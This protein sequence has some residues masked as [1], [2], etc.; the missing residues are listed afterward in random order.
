MNIAEILKQP[1]GRRLEFK[2]TLPTVADLAK[3]IVAFSNDAGGELFIG[4]QDNP[5]E[6]IGLPEHELLKLEERISNII[7]DDCTPIIG[8]DISFIIVEDKHL[9]KIV[10]Y[11][12]SN[13]PYYLKAKGKMEGTY[14]RVGSSNRLASPEM[15]AELERQKW[16]IS[17]DSEMVHD[18]KINLADFSDFEAYYQEQTNEKLNTTTLRKLELIK[19]HQKQVLPTNAYFLFSNQ[20]LKRKLFPYAKIECARFKGVKSEEFIDQKTYD[21]S[22]ATQA[23]LAYEFVLRHV[24]QG[25]IVEGV[26]TKS[27]WEYPVKAVREV[28]RNAV[29][30]R[31]YSMTGKDIK[32]AVYDNMIE[33]TS[34]GKLLPSIDFNDSVSRQ[35]DIRNKVIAPIFKKLGIIDQW[36]NGLKLIADEMRDY[37]EIEFKWMDTGMQFQVLFVK[38][39]FDEKHFQKKELQTETTANFNELIQLVGTKLALSWH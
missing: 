22:I 5:R 8:A 26:Y 36:G 33:I 2:K 24:N 13:L 39:N 9:V 19:S 21:G 31:D 15:I 10:V 1:E 17:F 23:E 3:T 28:I 30:H 27:R 7:H 18:F 20:D 34:P 29:V 12:G 35:S 25:A 16:N 37:P 4:I 38:K 14:I 32:V 6:V 11:R